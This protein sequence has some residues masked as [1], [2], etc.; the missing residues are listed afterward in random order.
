ML[1]VLVHSP[2]GTEFNVFEE[3]YYH[4]VTEFAGII[5]LQQ[6]QKKK[7]RIKKNSH[8]N[9]TVPEFDQQ[10]ATISSFKIIWSPNLH[11]IDKVLMGFTSTIIVKQLNRPK[12]IPTTLHTEFNISL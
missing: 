1:A 10:L 3:W 8:E 7:K 6:V 5:S 12:K 4:G 2:Q 11:D 9:C